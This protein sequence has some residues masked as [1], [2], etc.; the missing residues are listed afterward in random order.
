MSARGAAALVVVLIVTLMSAACGG[1]DSRTTES[2]SAEPAGDQIAHTENLNPQDA[3]I[4]RGRYLVE[5]P[6]H[7]LH[8]HSEIDWQAPGHP[9]VSGRKAAGQPIPEASI[10]GLVY[11]ANLTADAETGIGAW[12]DAELGVAIREG[13]GRDGRRLFPLMPYM[14][15]AHMSDQDLAAVIAFL[16]TLDPVSNKVPPREL[17]QPV[18]DSLPPHQSIAGPVAHPVESNPVEYGAYLATL[19]NCVDCHTPFTQG[20]PI[21]SLAYA[22]GRVL[23]GPWGIIASPNITSDPS[24]IPHYNEDLFISTMRTCRSGARELHH[25]M[26]CRYYN[27]MTDEDLA[28]I[29][30]WVQTL[31]PIQHRVSNTDSPTPCALCGGVHG[32]GDMN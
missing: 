8:C 21:M 14:A 4:E 27:N 20:Q 18:I 9:T 23:D 16:R 29:F 12:T 25:L 24:G 22:G 26:P 30:A 17:P 5:G 15:Y 28:A 1:G 19:G 7:C 13:I 31:P 10:P 3:A 6:A 32:L 2:P 11:A